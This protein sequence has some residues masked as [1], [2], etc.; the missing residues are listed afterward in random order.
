[1][2]ITK[3]PKWLDNCLFPFKTVDE[4]PNSVYDEINNRLDQIT[5]SYPV[6]SVVMPAWNEELNI[7]GCLA[8]FSRMKSKVPFEIIIVN[9]NST[10]RT[11][12]VIDKFHVKSFLEKR[13]G[14]GPARQLGQEKAS[15][16]YILTADSDCYYPPDWINI[17]YDHLTKPGVSCV[18]GRYSFLES[19][20]AP[21]WQLFLY[22][23]IKDM[24]AEIRHIKRPYL[25][26]CTLSMG[27]PREVGLKIGFDTRN[28]RGT[29]GRLCFDLMKYGKIVQVRDR[30]SRLWT[31]QRTIAK[32]GSLFKAFLN[33]AKKELSRIYSYT[34]PHPPH[35]TK[36]SENN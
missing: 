26:S 15:G 1:M 12:E 14:P 30:K 36:T 34:T 9:N 35:D 22:E 28:I 7:I 8:S 18:Y 21:R 24:M 10:D 3:H 11:Q 6:V 29:D 5:S 20:E 17:M 25:N 2:Q 33:R 27:Y 31:G 13:Q 23:T 32:D 16:K 4:V 19:P